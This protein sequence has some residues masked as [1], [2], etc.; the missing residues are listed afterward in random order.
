MPF[1]AARGVPAGSRKLMAKGIGVYAL[2][3]FVAF[4]LMP[5]FFSQD[6]QILLPTFFTLAIFFYFSW[7]LWLQVQ[8][9][10]FGEIGFIYLAFA[11]AYTVFPAYGF[12][13][14]DA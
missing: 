10:I 5:T 11:V 3:W 4:L 8:D 9:N 6:L 1:A 14:L 13:T 2:L 7:C 12:L